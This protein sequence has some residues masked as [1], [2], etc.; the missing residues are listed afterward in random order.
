MN[1]KNKTLKEKAAY[2][3]ES[4]RNSWDDIYLYIEEHHVM[5]RN[6]FSKNYEETRDFIPTADV[7]ELECFV[8]VLCDFI[9]KYPNEEIIQMCIERKKQLELDFYTLDFAKE[10]E[11]AKKVLSEIKRQD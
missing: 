8:S 3:A 7:D 11:C 10:I 5:I 2:F 4:Q 1:L 9:K 6:H